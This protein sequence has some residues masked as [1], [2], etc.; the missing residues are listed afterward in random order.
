MRFHNLIDWMSLALQGLHLQRMPFA[1]RQPLYLMTPQTHIGYLC[2][3]NASLT[4]SGVNGIWRRRAPVAS[5][6]FADK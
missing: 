3:V 1:R 6:T 4:L 2:C 5:K